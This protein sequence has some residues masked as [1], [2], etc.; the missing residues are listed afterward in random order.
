MGIYITELVDF[1]LTLS[2]NPY[3]GDTLPK[4]K[5]EAT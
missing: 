3:P 2:T 1:F 4:N 5:E